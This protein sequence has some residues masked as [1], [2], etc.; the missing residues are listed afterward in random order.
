M[1]VIGLLCVVSE[2]YGLS[3]LGYFLTLG[4]TY[5]FVAFGPNSH[6]KLKAEN[7]VAHLI[8]WPVLL[9]MVRC[10][11]LLPF[12][13]YSVKITVFSDSQYYMSQICF[14]HVVLFFRHN[15]DVGG[16]E[17]IHG[18]LDPQENPMLCTNESY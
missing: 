14:N 15:I 4:G 13:S 10:F 12:H 3:F 18:Y 16:F 17:D 7:I 2:R 5:L 11:L 6:E 9:Y 1:H 8:G